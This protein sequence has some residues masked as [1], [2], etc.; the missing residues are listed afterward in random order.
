MVTNER[1]RS[2]LNCLSSFRGRTVVP[3][4]TLSE[5]PGAYSD[6]SWGIFRL[7]HMRPL[8]HWL[9]SHEMGIVLWRMSRDHH[10]NVLPHVQSLSGPC[11]FTGR[12]ALRTTVP[13]C[14]FHYGFLQ[15]RLGRWMHQAGNL[16]VLDK[17]F[18]ALAHQLPGVSASASSLG[19]GSGRCC[20]ASMCWSAKTTLHPVQTPTSRRSMIMSH[21]TTHLPS[22]PL[23]SGSSHC[24]L[25][26]FQGSSIMWPMHSHVSFTIPGEWRLNPQM[27][28]IRFG[29]ASHE[30]SHC[31]LYYSLTLAPLGTDVLAHSWPRVLRKY[32]FPPPRTNTGQ[33]LYTR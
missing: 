11:L 5:A 20:L 19:G 33:T 17:A 31:Q 21:A 23:E 4:K 7:L 18:T 1:A 32:A 30:S 29:E 10:V 3:L 6:Y 24:V 2:V 27:V 9:H 13:S 14:R 25:S 26:T 22:P 16:R 28:W 12:G 8:Q 15:C